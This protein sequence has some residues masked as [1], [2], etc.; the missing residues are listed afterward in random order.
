MEV[1]K[2]IPAGAAG[3]IAK[4]EIAPPVD[5]T[6]KP[7]AAVF[8]TLDSD[9]DVSVKAGAARVGACSGVG[10]GVGGATSVV[11]GGDTAGEDPDA[12]AEPG[13]GVGVM[14]VIVEAPA[15]LI[16]VIVNV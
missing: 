12:G 10:C 2:L 1:L 16:A 3:E 7:V 5:E 13:D 6:E 15:I 8:T 14:G 4:L 9:D 11:I